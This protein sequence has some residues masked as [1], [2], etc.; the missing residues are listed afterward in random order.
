MSHRR[1]GGGGGGAR[2]V[3]GVYP[4]PPAFTSGAARCCCC[5]WPHLALIRALGV[6]GETRC[7]TR[8][9][10]SG[11]LA[12][13]SDWLPAACPGRCSGR[14]SATPGPLQPLEVGSWK[15][16]VAF[17]FRLSF[18]F[19]WRLCVVPV[20]ALA[21]AGSALALAE[22][23]CNFVPSGCRLLQLQASGRSALVT[24]FFEQHDWLAINSG[25]CWSLCQHDWLAINSGWFSAN[26][27]VRVLC[28]SVSA[29]QGQAQSTVSGAKA[30]GGVSGS[31]H[32]ARRSAS[33]LLWFP[34]D[35]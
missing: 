33:G 34:G 30:S 4:G 11:S 13:A 29:C 35:P 21:L 10:V 5:C 22:Y 32:T 20:P 2:A 16:E 15:L 26:A 7:T 18:S 14:S 19:G 9:R 17:V 27:E 25:C 12:L 23:W 1:G 28:E 8:L 24:A 31:N 3:F 6:R